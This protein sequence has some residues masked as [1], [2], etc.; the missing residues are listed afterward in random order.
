M[1]INKF[2]FKYMCFVV[3]KVRKHFI[4]HSNFIFLEIYAFSR[5]N[6]IVKCIVDLRR[7][8]GK[9]RNCRENKSISS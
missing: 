6:Y 3:S 5:Y 9:Q 1:Y 2:G 4:V 7:F 8:Y